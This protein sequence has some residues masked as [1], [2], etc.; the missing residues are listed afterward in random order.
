[1]KIHGAG[2]M[3]M[4]FFLGS[5][6]NVHIRRALRARRN[7]ASGW[8]MIVTM[9]TLVITGFGLYYLADE[10]NRPAWSV[11]HWV[12]GLGLVGLLVAHVLLGRSS[13]KVRND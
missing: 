13:R 11:V 5:L 1:M 6:L 10:G 4:L 12:I 2:A 3:S 8:A 7:L 9:A